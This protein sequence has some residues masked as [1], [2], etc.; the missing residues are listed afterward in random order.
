[1]AIEGIQQP[2]ILQVYETI[3]LRKYDGIH[4]F[5][6]DWYQDVETVYLIDGEKTTYSKEKLKRM[7]EYLDKQG[8]LYFIEV[9]KDVTYVPIGDVI[10]W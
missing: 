8:E 9:L 1:M 7:Y 4:D 3:R 5:T 6:F 10:F 2:E